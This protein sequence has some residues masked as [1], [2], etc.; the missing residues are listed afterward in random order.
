[1]LA[2]AVADPGGSV[3]AGPE[4]AA[5]I[6]DGSEEDMRPVASSEL[7]AALN[8]LLEGFCSPIL[9]IECAVFVRR[10]ISNLTSITIECVE[11]GTTLL[12]FLRE[13]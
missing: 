6:D 9:S 10:V 13:A 3:T 8:T 1:M 5:Q 4:A 7:N 2:D 12:M 11:H